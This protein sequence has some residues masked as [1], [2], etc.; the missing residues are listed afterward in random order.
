MFDLVSLMMIGAV[1]ANVLAFVAVYVRLAERLT[2]VE[3]NIEHLMHAQ[4]LPIPKSKTA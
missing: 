2:R 4:H 1:L 3:T